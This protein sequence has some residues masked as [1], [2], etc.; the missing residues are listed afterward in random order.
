MEPQADKRAGK[1][2]GM[3]GAAIHQLPHIAIAR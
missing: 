1:L 2:C 3:P